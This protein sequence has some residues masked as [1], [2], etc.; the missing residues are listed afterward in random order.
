MGQV[1]TRDTQ[2]QNLCGYE[3]RDFYE[4][5][6]G[7][8]KP[9]G[10]NPE[11]RLKDSNFE[12]SHSPKYSV[13]VQDPQPAPI[14]QVGPP[15]AVSPPVQAQPV[16]A[17]AIKNSDLR[18]SGYD[19]HAN[20]QQFEQ[21]KTMNMINPAAKSRLDSLKPFDAQSYP[22]LMRTYSS[23]P[24]GQTPIKHKTQNWSYQGQ[25]SK[26]VPH[27]FGRLISNDGYVIDG[28]FNEGQPHGAVRKVQVNGA[29]Y[30]GG[31]NNNQQY[32]QKG[33]LV[34]ANGVV[35]ECDNWTNGLANGN[36]VIRNQNRVLYQGGM[37]NG[38]KR[39]QGTWYDERNKCTDKGVFNDDF[40][41][42]EGTR[43]WDDG[44]VYVGTFK[45]G[46]EDGR[47]NYTYVDGRKFQGTFVNGR[48]NGEGILTTDNGR[49]NKVT[50]RD[51]RRV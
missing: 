22:E 12:Q 48:P 33:T 30:E 40:I 37:A 32:H 47:G 24:Q 21:V 9:V 1:C 38:K 18:D 39:G 50:F 51:G 19:V 7:T 23:Y 26:G 17:N 13:P 8:L 41:E 28:F 5:E 34:E 10:Q 44:R 11:V 27:G 46:Q 4:N 14:R 15:V 49:Q 2:N 36:T 3:D 45:R 42:G 29:Y 25:M 31:F 16:V 43:I 6:Y 35:T 20:A